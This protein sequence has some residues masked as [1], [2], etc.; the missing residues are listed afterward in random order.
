MVARKA[1]L[2]APT[3]GTYAQVLGIA[4]EGRRVFA[5]HYRSD[6]ADPHHSDE[7]GE[8]VV[9]DRVGFDVLHRIPVGFQP[10]SVAVDPVARRAYVV[11]YSQESYSLTVIDTATF[12]V[13]TEID[14]AS[15][16]VDVAVHHGSATVYVS[17]PLARHLRVIS[18]ATFQ[19]T[20][21]IDVG[22]A[23]VGIAVDQALGTVYA[24]LTY[25]SGN[26]IPDVD[27]LAVV[28]HAQLGHQI[29]RL[30]VG[31]DWSQ[32]QAVAV[33]PTADRVYVANL[34]KSGVPLGVAVFDRAD[35][36]RVGFVPVTPGPRTIAV[37]AALGRVYVNTVAGLRVIDG[38]A[39]AVVD[40]HDFGGPVHGLAVDPQTSQVYAGGSRDGVLT[41]L[42]LLNPQP[43]EDS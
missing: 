27:R 21:T 20:G 19:V 24:A 22:P 38:A 39:M 34:A 40:S 29:R 12:T 42:T 37:D 2:G 11:N 14:L 10:R 5:T 26:G 31:P 1:H 33:D 41:Q 6:I 15:T 4:L 7:P 23:P 43:G 36:S 30:A 13:V 35:H 8:L 25:H 17:M 9:L 18:G 32:P 16:P 3:P 28:S